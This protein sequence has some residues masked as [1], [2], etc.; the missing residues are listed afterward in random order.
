MTLISVSSASPSV[1]SGRDREV[2]KKAKCQ[3]QNTGFISKSGKD[4][5]CSQLEEEY[6]LQNRGEHKNVLKA[7]FK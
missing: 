2:Q 7:N 5:N 4:C 1:I 3:E 6:R